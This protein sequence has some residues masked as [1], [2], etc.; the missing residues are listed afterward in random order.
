MQV[1][2]KCVLCDEQI[3]PYQE[4]YNHLEIDETRSVDICQ[5]CIRK[6]VKLQQKNTATLFPTKTAKKFLKK[7]EV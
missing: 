7:Q 5:D 6:V 1:I 4:T 3:K 2:H